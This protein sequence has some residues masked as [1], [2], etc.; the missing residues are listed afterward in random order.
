[1]GTEYS[2]KV[3]AKNK[4]GQ[5][6][7]SAPASVTAGSLPLKPTNFTL[8]TPNGIHGQVRLSWHNLDQP[9]DFKTEL[10]SPSSQ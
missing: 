9:N 7:M 4:F 2:F 8:S 1:M 5:S 6:P 3:Q 10:Y